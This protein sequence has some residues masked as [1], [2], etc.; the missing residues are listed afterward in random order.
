MNFK[1]T[2]SEYAIDQT[3]SSCFGVKGLARE[4]NM[5]LLHLV[6]IITTSKFK[7]QS[8]WGANPSL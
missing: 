5:A 2:K 8:Y 7:N 3:L 1:D 4:T 6:I